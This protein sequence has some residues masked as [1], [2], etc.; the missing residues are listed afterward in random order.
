MEPR[1]GRKH[2]RVV[3][4]DGFPR[5]SFPG[6]LGALDTLAIEY[7]WNTRTILL[8]P[9]EARAILDKTR[10]KWRAKMRG[11]KDHLFRPGGGPVNL[12]PQERAEDP[13]G[14]SGAPASRAVP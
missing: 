7:L 14:A 13:E 9:E 12:Y 1:I 10:K 8:D 11:W 5:M 3:A 6:I 2:M 4:L